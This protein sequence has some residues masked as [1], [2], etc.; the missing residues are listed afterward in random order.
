MMKRTIGTGTFALALMLSAQAGFAQDQQPRAAEPPKTAKIEDKKHPDYMRCKTE[1]VIGSRA[2]T[3]KVC[4]TNRQ[5]AEV[6]RD[7]SSLANRMVEDNRSR[8]G[9]N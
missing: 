2:K 8:P 9:G 3:R 5:W 7:S 6:E 4:L 1:S